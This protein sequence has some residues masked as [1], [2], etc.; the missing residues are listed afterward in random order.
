M[1]QSQ[2]SVIK[3]SSF[4]FF[5]SPE[6]SNNKTGM[7]G[8]GGGRV[9]PTFLPGGNNAFLSTFAWHK[10]NLLSSSS[11]LYFLQTWMDSWAMGGH[12]T[13]SPRGTQMLSFQLL[14][15][16]K[17][18]CC[19]QVQFFIFSIPLEVSDSTPGVDGWG[20]RPPTYSPRGTLMLS[21]SNFCMTQSQSS[22]IK[23][24]S[25]VFSTA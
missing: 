9:P 4:I 7:G 18:I 25:F 3:F 20:M 19:H 24:S 10:V 17:S 12:T 8:E 6:V 1:T 13:F 22:D 11:V 21:A 16:T 5:L 15:N 2:S 14:H 23:F